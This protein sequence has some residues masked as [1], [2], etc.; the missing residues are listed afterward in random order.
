MGVDNLLLVDEDVLRPC[1][2]ACQDLKETADRVTEALA[3][4]LLLPW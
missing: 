4:I 3:M 1:F 2:L